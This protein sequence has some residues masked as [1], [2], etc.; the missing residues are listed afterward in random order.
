MP[1]SSGFAADAEHHRQR[2]NARAQIRSDRL[3]DLFLRAEDVEQ[4]V[5]HLKGQPDR[6]AE[7]LHRVDGPPGRAGEIGRDL[8]AGG[9]QRGGLARDHCEVILE[10]GG[11]VMAQP[12]L[13]HF[14]L[15][16]LDAGL[17]RRA[18]EVFLEAPAQFEGAAEQIVAGDQRRGR[19]VAREAP[20]ACRG[21][22]S[23]RR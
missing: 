12:P 8:A 5:D 17:R 15:G 20:T 18:H 11:R 7:M 10:A 1:F 21:A 16:Q 3:A 2:R 4:I 6:G 22:A 9:E 23:R 13:H 14:A 19:A